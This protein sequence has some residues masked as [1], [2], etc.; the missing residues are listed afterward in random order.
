MEFQSHGRLLTGTPCARAT[1]STQ[2]LTSAQ[3]LACCHDLRSFERSSLCGTPPDNGFTP[4]ASR[5]VALKSGMVSSIFT[6]SSLSLIPLIRNPARTSSWTF[7]L[8]RR[9]S[10]AG[11]S[12]AD[13]SI[14]ST[15]NFL[16]GTTV[17]VQRVRRTDEAIDE[18][19]QI[20]ELNGMKM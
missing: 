1:A 3:T 20:L 8:R 6:N 14:C 10:K 13:P 16:K 4:K 17:I 2:V 9:V 11:S 5:H 18:D 12:G 19:F 7:A 15:V